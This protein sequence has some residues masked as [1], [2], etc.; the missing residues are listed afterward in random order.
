MNGATRFPRISKKPTERNSN[1]EN[2]NSAAARFLGPARKS[3]LYIMQERNV[4]NY[5]A[6]AGYLALMAFYSY[7]LSEHLYSQNLRR[8]LIHVLAV[9]GYGLIVCHF[10]FEAYAATAETPSA[11]LQLPMPAQRV[12][13]RDGPKALPDDYCHSRTPAAF[14]VN[15]SPSR[16]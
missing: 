12:I 8:V 5:I 7:E 13:V 9:I 14:P 2:S 1:F 10:V 3:L 15:N 16:M 6:L 4:S 11:Q